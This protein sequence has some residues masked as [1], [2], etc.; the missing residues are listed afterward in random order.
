MKSNNI[1]PVP[2]PTVPVIDAPIPPGTVP[3][4]FDIKPA[5][6]TGICTLFEVSPDKPRRSSIP[7]KTIGINKLLISSLCVRQ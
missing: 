6:S 4:S 7:L 2:F 5:I 1:P 3:I